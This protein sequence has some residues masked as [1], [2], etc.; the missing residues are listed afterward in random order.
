[1]PLSFEALLA[2]DWSQVTC[3][4]AAELIAARG[5]AC[6][7]MKLAQAGY[8]QPV[9]HTKTAEDPPA[10]LELKTILD[11]LNPFGSAL[12]TM[13]AA[14]HP[15]RTPGITDPGWGTARAGIAG[16]GLGL[17]LGAISTAMRPEKKRNWLKTLLSGA[18]MGGGIGAGAGAAYHYGGLAALPTPE[19][20]AAAI[21]SRLTAIDTK[22]TAQDTPGDVA[23]KL[24]TER[25]RL[26]TKVNE[27][28]ATNPEIKFEPAVIAAANSQQAA[29]AGAAGSDAS[30]V[31]AATKGMTGQPA[32]ADG[33]F[34]DKSVQTPAHAERAS[35][36]KETWW[37]PS[38][39]VPA[40]P[41]LNE[42]QGVASDN[43]L[44]SGLTL[45]GAGGGALAGNAVVHKS[46]HAAAVRGQLT[47]A[48]AENAD[49]NVHKQLDPTVK[50]I[51]ATQ[52]E[53]VPPKRP[54]YKP[55]LP[56][57]SEGAD[58][59]AA[60]SPAAS[61]QMDK[62]ITDNVAKTRA[63]EADAR[64]AKSSGDQ[65]R[66]RVADKAVA[67]ELANA[68]SFKL[69]RDTL[70]AQPG[71]T[72]LKRLAA[73][74]VTP[75]TGTAWAKQKWQRGRGMATGSGIGSLAGMGLGLTANAVMN[76][77]NGNK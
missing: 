58:T 3:Q 48:F 4:Q 57:W 44:I 67:A 77:L 2:T 75:P 52:Q 55:S 30:A 13:D 14:S 32:S 28:T 71:M 54:W 31:A 22:L 72:N 7:M 26:L 47:N 42:L 37:S 46:Q 38:T 34:G 68:N 19:T 5:A 51:L 76:Y 45:A 66:I 40:A 1:M 12:P 61:T 23:A 50:N 65:A 9:G 74:K 8:Q 39:K 10:K 17:G 16:A 56:N 41:T 6:G 15:H 36:D 35:A 49:H 59:L 25:G 18:V 69:Q 73:A 20:E 29:V 60:H 53:S 11:R 21:A 62:L 70:H 63:V 27:L 33:T 43:K 24:L 64:V